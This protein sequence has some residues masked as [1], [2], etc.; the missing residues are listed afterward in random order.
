MLRVRFGQIALLG[1]LFVTLLPG[2]VAAQSGIAG[3]VSDATGA[4][5]P[6]VAVEV[7]SPVLIEGTRTAYTD[8]QG[9][10]SLIDLRPGVYT[11]VFSL[12]GFGTVRREAIELPASFTATVN[13]E[14]SVGAIGE[15]ISVSG[16]SPIVDVQNTARNQVMSREVID[17]VPNSRSWSSIGALT[18]GIKMDKPNVG[19]AEF[20]QN[21]MLSA[22]GAEVTQTAIEIDGM[23]INVNSSGNNLMSYPDNNLIQ[24]VVYQTNGITAETSRG[25]MRINMV[26][27][28]GGNTFQTLAFAGLTP[29][30]FVSTN[31]SPEVAALGVR[32]GESVQHIHDLSFSPGGPIIR[33]KLWFFGSVRYLRTEQLT[34]NTVQ[35]NG[36]QG[37][38]DDSIKNGLLRLTWQVTPRN[39][40]SAFYMQHWKWRGHTLSAFVD[41]EEAASVYRTL[42]MANSQV[43]WT[44]T[45]TSRLLVEAGFSK[46]PTAWGGFNQPGRYQADPGNVRAC[47]ATPCYWEASYDQTGPF[48]ASAA[49]RDLD[50]L[51][52][53]HATGLESRNYTTRDIANVAFSYV[54]GS[55]ALKFGAETEFGQSYTF[56]DQNNAGLEQQYRNGVPTS[57]LIYN[58]PNWGTGPFLDS[59]AGFYAQDTW[60]IARL[61]ATLGVRAELFR[62]SLREQSAPPGRFAPARDYPAVPNLPDWFDVVPRLGAAYDLF[63]TGKTALK[64]TFSKA[65]TSESVGF[66]S[67]YSSMVSSSETR[68]W[69]DVDRQGRSLPTNGDDIAQDNEIGPSQNNQFGIRAARNPAPDIKRGYNL[70]YSAGV[71]HEILPR[72]SVSATYYRR[73]F[74]RQEIQDNIL[75]SLSDWTPVTI[76]NPLDGT[77]IAAYNLDLNKRGLVEIVDRNTPNSDLRNR[78]Y[79]G[80]E[81]GASARF[82]GSAM[83]FGGWSIERTTNKTC[84]GSTPLPPST[85][86]QPDDPNTLRFCNQGGFDQESGMDLPM[87]W[88]SEFKLGLNVPLKWGIET[89]AGFVSFPARESQIDWRIT[90]TTRYAADCKGACT[91]GALVIPAMTESA[92]VVRLVPPGTNYLDRWNQ[93]DFGAKRTFNFG[94]DRRMRVGVTVFNLFNNAAM[95]AENTNYGATLGTPTDIMVPRL[96]RLEAQ[97]TF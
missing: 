85:T 53:W 18:P 51:A 41:P 15:T 60:T 10:Y 38:S 32:G 54:T 78:M 71:D 31:I 17:S 95:L 77:P 2:T 87:P 79:N 74:Y 83:A 45:V 59:D 63:G 5:L 97:F 19:G 16:Q 91:P 20:A 24:E 94:N 96:V 66:A 61:T 86:P 55:H 88:L 70:T 75:R 39:K 84:D 52:R 3:L 89:S 49:K 56:R 8:G 82:G 90:P 65:M 48:Y 23:S 27:K 68:T 21:A 33:D 1:G 72:V 9:R 36:D 30:A 34:Q 58:A 35:D 6:G 47:L 7:S 67:R 92:L 40:I 46:S 14:L 28:E 76:Y 57:V 25:G 62:S 29:G 12:A 26:P 13:A 4:V 64:F 42:N 81:L 37:V 73:G 93:F 11:V 44:S 22:R 43:K 50:T 69:I 80:F